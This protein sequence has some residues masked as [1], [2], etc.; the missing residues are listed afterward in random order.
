MWRIVACLP[1]PF[2]FSVSKAI[3]SPLA[4]DEPCLLLSDLAPKQVKGNPYPL[5]MWIE[6]GFKDF[7][8]GGLRWE[9]SKI[10]DAQRMERLMLVMS[11]P[12]L[13]LLRFVNGA[14]AQLS[15]AS[16][17][18]QRLSLVMLGWLRLLACAIRDL[19][20][21][22]TPFSPYIFPIS[23]PRKNTYP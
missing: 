5:R 17:P 21:T 9:H 4:A 20:L 23:H 1:S 18:A 22:E 11:L 2:K 13:H 19:P 7:K 15:L 10:A 3:P 6:A 8:R 12:L 16:D 14:S